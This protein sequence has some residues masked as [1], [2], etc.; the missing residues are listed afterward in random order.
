MQPPSLF[1]MPALTQ[2]NTLLPSVVSCYCRHYCQRVCCRHRLL[3]LLPLLITLC[4]SV[5]QL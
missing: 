3:L 1:G 2:F 5:L 4:M